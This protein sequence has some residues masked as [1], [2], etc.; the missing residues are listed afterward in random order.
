MAWQSQALAQSDGDASWRGVDT[1]RP[2]HELEPGMAAGAI[3]KRFEDGRVWPR[4]SIE[5][6]SWGRLPYKTW[7]GLIPAAQVYAPD[8][9]GEPHYI[10]TG[11]TVGKGY[12]LVTGAHEAGPTHFIL[13]GAQTLTNPGAGVVLYFIA[14]D[15]SLNFIGTTNGV[16]V[17]AQVYATGQNPMAYKRFTDP[18]TLTDNLIL[19]TDDLRDGPGEDG[20]RGRA[21]RIMSGQ[22]PQ[23]IPLNGHDVWDVARLIPVYNGVM[24]LRHGNERHY[25][26]APAIDIG[27]SQIQLNSPQAWANGDR[28]LYVAFPSSYILG[29]SPPNPNTLYFVK[30]ISGNKVEL[31]TTASLT[32][33]LDMSGASLGMF[34][35]E[36]QALTP[37][38]YGNGAPT[39]IMQPDGA[40]QTSFQT[41]FKAAQLQVYVSS[42]TGTTIVNAPNHRLIPGD[43]T[44]YVH[45]GTPT[46]YYAFPLNNDA[47]T[48]HLTLAE[49]LI[50]ANAQVITFSAG[51]Y[52]IKTGASGVPLPPCREGLYYAG[53][54]L[55]VNGENNVV[56]S[57][58]LDFL[59]F[60]PFSATLNVNLGESDPITSLVPLGTDPT[61]KDVV[62]VG[63]ANSVLALI[64][65]TG[66]SSGWQLKEVTREYGF[67]AA[68]CSL[69]AG[70]DAW[71]FSRKGVVSVNQ[72][73]Q[74]A[75]LGVAVPVSQSM[76]GYLAGVDWTHIAQASAETWNNR[77]F[78]SVA[79]KGQTGDGQV[80]NNSVLV[81][82]FLNEAEDPATG[83]ADTSYRRSG[84][85]GLWEGAALQVLKWARHKVFGEERLTFVNYDGQVCWLGEGWTDFGVVPIADELLTRSYTRGNNLT[86]KFLKGLLVLDQQTANITVSVVAPGYN[87]EKVIKTK[88]YSPTKYAVYGQAD[89]AP[90]TGRYDLP[91]REDYSLT[92]G[93]LVEGALDIHQNI[94]EELRM[95]VRDWGVQLR[96]RNSAGSAR[97]QSVSVDFVVTGEVASRK[98]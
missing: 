89:Y 95:R 6:Q 74:A 88:A 61:G 29:T 68:L 31:Y 43:K 19:V 69:I 67:Q 14:A 32:T 34:Y 4:Y 96:I 49:A 58:P 76:A 63:K 45:S 44:D 71:G 13:N 91:Y 12:A 42:L 94:S 24:L 39:L 75:I 33:K 70:T 26:G 21:W 20:G 54:F 82:N 3:N 10:F 50:G 37:G 8:S 48:L 23:A 53:R 56:I 83:G 47:L 66:A 93:E 7:R 55:G 22:A 2:P 64:G 18:D 38:F 15:P 79:M 84:W 40:G 98:T 51:D 5:L 62:I 30:L 16:S 25:F 65:L 11:L 46:T 41:G 9:L 77:Y 27:T 36:R 85:E 59:H 86:K 1:Q 90:N 81:Y 73:S 92:P 72:T 60:T 57:D 28:V 80:V 87:E 52:V 17:T 97:I 78:L 35:L